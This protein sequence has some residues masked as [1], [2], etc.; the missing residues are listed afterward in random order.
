MQWTNQR[1]FLTATSARRPKLETPR[2]TNPSRAHGQG[3][4]EPWPPLLQ[5]WHA[6]A[7]APSHGLAPR[8]LGPGPHPGRGTLL[9]HK[10]RTLVSLKDTE[11]QHQPR[12][13]QRPAGARAPARLASADGHRGGTQAS[14]VPSVSLRSERGARVLLR[15]GCGRHG[16]GG[17]WG[18]YGNTPGPRCPRLREAFATLELLS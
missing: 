3:D 14:S 12:E 11:T 17:Q 10:L 18:H 16:G 1:Y 7:L 6:S 2:F 8:R 4:A 9:L 5:E 13:Q 15:T